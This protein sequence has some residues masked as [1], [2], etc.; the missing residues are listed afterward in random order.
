MTVCH[1]TVVD[2]A[3]REWTV[4]PAAVAKVAPW[5]ARMPEVLAQDLAGMAQYFPHWFLAASTRGQPARCARRACQGAPLV[6][7]AKSPCGTEGALRCARCGTAGEADGLLWL[8]HIPSLARPE[9]AF[10]RRRKALQRAGF[11]EVVAG[12]AVYLLVPLMLVYPDE[13]PNVQPVVRY[14][15]RW[16]DA[17]DLPRSSGAHHLIQGGRACI[18]SWGQWTAMPV[19]AVLQERMANHVASLLKVAAGQRPRQAFIGRIHHKRWQPER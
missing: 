1:H 10:Q 5:A 16:L 2:G 13:W 18:F 11:P 17:L 12:E 3:E 6:P 15:R 19:H 4:D 8:G 7:S 9:L 14:A